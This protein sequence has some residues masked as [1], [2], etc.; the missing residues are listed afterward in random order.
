MILSMPSGWLQGDVLSGTL[1]AFKSWLANNPA[2]A[3]EAAFKLGLR[4]TLLACWGACATVRQ[5]GSRHWQCLAVK[6]GSVSLAGDV[7]WDCW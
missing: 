1:A 5:V 2:S 4:P 6:V 3:E 7:F